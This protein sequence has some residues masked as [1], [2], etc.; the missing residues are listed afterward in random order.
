MPNEDPRQADVPKHEGEDGLV[1]GDTD[2]RTRVNEGVSDPRPRNVMQA[3]DTS[4]ADL[5][6]R[7]VM[8]NPAGSPIVP[9]HRGRYI[10]PV[11][12]PLNAPSSNQQVAITQDENNRTG[13]RDQVS[14]RPPLSGDVEQYKGN[15]ASPENEATHAPFV[16]PVNNVNDA[17]Q[18]DEEAPLAEA[19]AQDPSLMPKPVEEDATPL[20]L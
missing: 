11:N 17:P 2:H 5:E 16:D 20:D 14:P 18:D 10:D 7:R 15:A 12:N 9:A 6:A 4:R 8:Y 19:D 3:T 13:A 1:R